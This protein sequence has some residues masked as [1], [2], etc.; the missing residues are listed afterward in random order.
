MAGL[1]VAGWLGHL[2][3][4]EFGMA[5]RADFST[6]L[7]L[8]AGVLVGLGTA[9]GS[10]CTSGHGVCGISRLSARSMLATVMF[11]ACG[12]ATVFVI[13]HLLGAY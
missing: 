12:M 11:I 5:M 3:L 1:I 8:A 7:L 2:L 9:V 10:G 13:R 4:P 6:P